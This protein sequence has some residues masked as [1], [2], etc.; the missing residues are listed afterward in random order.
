MLVKDLQE[1]EFDLLFADNVDDELFV[2][3]VLD[4]VAE[5]GRRD[6]LQVLEMLEERIR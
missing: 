3:L 2:A 5:G 6:P 4:E 1:A